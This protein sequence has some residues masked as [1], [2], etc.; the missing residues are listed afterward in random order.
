MSELIDRFVVIEGLDGAGTTT[1]AKALAEAL[2][3]TERV[4]LTCEPT[5]GEIGRL[6]RRILHG[7]VPAEPRTVAHL[8]AA[9]RTE[10]LYHGPDSVTARLEAE[11]LVICDRYLFSSLA[12]QSVH[13]GF[14][15][16][17]R[18]NEP[19]PLPRYL[20]YLD[21]DPDLGEQRLSSREKRDIYERLAFQKEVKSFYERTLELYSRS[22]IEIH[23][24]DGSLPVEELTESILRSLRL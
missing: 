12:Y 6:I 7:E 8:Y 11:Y 9:D 10:H 24:L 4:Y 1:Q 13:C 23:R 19:F 2:G 18:L 20:F 3:E 15:F 5:E 22:G 17:Y 16:V 21:I 14:D